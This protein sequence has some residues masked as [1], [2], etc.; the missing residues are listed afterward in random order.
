MT[1]LQ[2]LF[3][4]PSLVLPELI[5]NSGEKAQTKFVEFFV[6][7]IE[8]AGTRAAYLNA[9]NQFFHWCD[10]NGFRL[11]SISPTIAATYVR[12]LSTRLSAPTVKLHLAAIRM[13]FDWLVIS[14]IVDFNPASSVR[15]PKYAAKKGKTP[16]LDPKEARTLLD[17]IDT[18]TLK[19][20]RDRALIGVLTFSFAR[21][22]AALG[23]NLGD[24]YSQGGRKWFRLHEKGGK[25][26][27]VPAHHLARDYLE[28][29]L[30]A[31][32]FG[33]DEQ[34][35]LFR[36]FNSKGEITRNRFDRSDAR[37]M[38]VRRAEE[39]EIQTNISCHT[40]RAT[41]ITAY[42]LNGG[43]LEHAMRIACHESAR[44]TKLYDRTSDQVSVDE[45]ERVR[46]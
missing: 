14:H 28:D 35:P 26:H 27:D 21:I 11:E 8:N 19:G 5:A 24:F 31:G 40:F 4:G 22:S 6:A 15:G 20:K 12:L 23:M 2:P 46:I 1:A 13:L 37:R 42:L 43:S 9:V 41:G 25:L 29:Y 18:A 33:T 36:S 44:T 39:A 17:A 16:V 32:Q 30:A 38:I 7:Q 3:L 10:S 45:I 34:E